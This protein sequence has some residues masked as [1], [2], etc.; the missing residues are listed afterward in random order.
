MDFDG[1]KFC[2]KFQL[3]AVVV[4]ILIVG[5]KYGNLSVTKTPISD[6]DVVLQSRS[7]FGEDVVY[8]FSGFSGVPTLPCM[9]TDIT[10]SAGAIVGHGFSKIIQQPYFIR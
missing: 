2:V 7:D 5:I 9:C 4:L 8:F 3:A 6:D 1:S 10:P